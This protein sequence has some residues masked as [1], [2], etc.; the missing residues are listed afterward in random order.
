MIRPSKAPGKPGARGQRRWNSRQH[1]DSLAHHPIPAGNGTQLGAASR[2]IRVPVIPPGVGGNIRH[3]A[4]AASA[5]RPGEIYR[6]PPW[7]AHTPESTSDESMNAHGENLTPCESPSR[8]NFGRLSLDGDESIPRGRGALN[9]SPSPACKRAA[10][11]DL[12]RLPG[13]QSPGGKAARSSNPK[14]CRDPQPGLCNRVKHDQ[15]TQNGVVGSRRIP[16]CAAV[17]PAIEKRRQPVS[18]NTGYEAVS[19]SNIKET[20]LPKPHSSPNIHSVAN[21]HV[22]S[23]QI[24]RTSV[25]VKEHDRPPDK[26]AIQGIILESNSS[27]IS[28]DHLAEELKSIYAGLVM[29]EAKCIDVDASQAND[30]SAK[31]GPEQWQALIALHRTLLYEH[32]DFLMA[33]QH[34]SATPALRGLAVKYSMAARMWKHG[35]HAFLEVLRHRRPDAQEYMI[36]FIYL[37]YQMMGL[38]YE[39]VPAFLDTWIECLGDLSRYRMA[40]EDDKD[41]HAQWGNVASRWYAMASDRHPTVG[42]LNH[43]LGIL[44]RPSLRKFFFYAKSLTCVIPFPNARDSLST[45]CSP[46]IEDERA[47]RNNKQSAEALIVTLHALLFSGR[48]GIEVENVAVN[49]SCLFTKLPSIKLR[50][51]GVSLAVTNISS[52]LQLGA[53]NNEIGRLYR[54]ASRQSGSRLANDDMHPSTNLQQAW[55][56]SSPS[57]S[58]ELKFS[59]YCINSVLHSYEDRGDQRD[60]LAYVHTMLVWMHSLTILLS[61]TGNVHVNSIY[62]LLGPNSFFW[63]GLGAYLNSLLQH[64]GYEQG[65]ITEL[66][67]QG[68]AGEFPSQPTPPESTVPSQRNKRPSQ[69]SDWPLA[70]DYLIRGLVWTQWYFASTWFE[71]TASLDGRTIDTDDMQKRRVNRVLWLGFYLASHTEFLQYDR[72]GVYFSTPVAGLNT[73]FPEFAIASRTANTDPASLQALLEADRTQTPVSPSSATQS[74]VEDGFTV[75]QMPGQTAQRSE[76]IQQKQWPKRSAIRSSNLSDSC[77]KPLPEQTA[78]RVVDENDTVSPNAFSWG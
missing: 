12:P 16:H 75:I 68:C 67:G 71:G 70:E 22:P 61:R 76:T 17:K 34:P 77:T 57:P 18:L 38:L 74:E 29:V 40:I 44:E 78:V 37:A 2:R 24:P 1:E 60:T 72:Q 6:S 56:L 54:Q 47:Q 26:G 9:L 28:Q 48:S 4:Q 58:I 41:V 10:S 35:I 66:L 51:I 19:R 25:T 5:T 7:S 33:T 64:E 20:A 53:S 73:P 42:R 45:L 11:K 59:Y 63:G 69:R 46:I 43:H 55:S 36:S 15:I 3:G 21:V 23:E 8:A 30:P 52:L 50:E 62:L 27:P 13:R 49:A 39:T 14:G 65:D 32:H 31:L